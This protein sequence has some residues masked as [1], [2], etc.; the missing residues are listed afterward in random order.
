M[1]IGDKN[2]FAC[3]LGSIVSM[4]PQYF[5]CFVLW[6]GGQFIGEPDNTDMLSMYADSLLKAHKDRQKFTPAN[7]LYIDVDAFFSQGR[8]QLDEYYNFK[9]PQLPLFD[10]FALYLFYDDGQ[11]HYLWRI[12]HEYSWVNAY[13]PSY[14]KENFLY[15]IPED[16]FLAVA[17]EVREVINKIESPRGR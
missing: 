6:C 10:L 16:E 8:E 9:V 11:F 15:S 13:V 2:R 5:D 12:R 17:L 7:D 14:P 1:I 3:Q 4:E